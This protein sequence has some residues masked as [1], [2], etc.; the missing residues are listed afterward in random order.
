MFVLHTSKTHW[1]DA[2][3]QIIKIS[4]LDDSQGDKVK[5]DSA[6]HN[7]CPFKLLKQYMQ[8]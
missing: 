1:K 5:T 8:L 7:V 2:K 4:E 6:I 3:P